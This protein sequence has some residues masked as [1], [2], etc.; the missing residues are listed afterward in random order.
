MS[1]GREGLAG[2]Y[3]QWQ[4]RHR[5]ATRLAGW[6]AGLVCRWDCGG[7]LSVVVPGAG[8]GVGEGERGNVLQSRLHSADPLIDGI[9]IEFDLQAVE[10]KTS[11][12]FGERVGAT[13]AVL[14]KLNGRSVAVGI[15][16]DVPDDVDLLR[17]YP[18]VQEGGES[19][20]GGVGSGCVGTWTVRV[21]GVDLAATSRFNKKID[22][23]VDRPGHV[24]A[25]VG[26]VWAAAGYRDDSKDRSE[27]DLLFLRHD[28]FRQGGEAAAKLR[29]M[30]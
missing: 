24:A 9:Q 8:S 3:P 29:V 5:G 10:F 14:N 28:G 16:V 15:C 17:G 13:G 6:R 27:G 23:K 26:H 30:F 19:V 12:G 11:Q 7:E 21:F 2:V 4:A 25:G 18:I 20:V 22:E 1:V